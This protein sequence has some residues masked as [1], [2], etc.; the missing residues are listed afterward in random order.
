M[1]SNRPQLLP[2]DHPRLP[3]FLDSRA[4]AWAMLQPHLDPGNVLGEALRSLWVREWMEANVEAFQVWA[5]VTAGLSRENLRNY[6]EQGGMRQL[7]LEL[8]RL[9]EYVSQLEQARAGLVEALR[10]IAAMRQGVANM[11]AEQKLD[12]IALMALEA[13]AFG[14]PGPRSGEE[15]EGADQDTRQAWPGTAE[16][17]QEGANADEGGGQQTASQAEEEDPPGQGEH[18]PSPADDG[19][20]V[21]P[22]RPGMQVFDAQQFRVMASIRNLT[23][24]DG[25]AYPAV[26]GGYDPA[27][28]L[29]PAG[30]LP[31][32]VARVAWF[33]YAAAPAQ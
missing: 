28:R 26:G 25:E 13:L 9:R 5:A 15:E 10:G 23:Q 7:L 27:R 19:Q 16:Q 31:V 12:Q 4:Q 21:H 18:A 11:T 22:L 20:G 24:E 3:E 2:P 8:E 17:T 6:A 1:S 29:D 30:P 33:E 32:D 14:R